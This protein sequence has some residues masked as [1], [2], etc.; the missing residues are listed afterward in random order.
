MPIFSPISASY[1]Q[2]YHNIGILMCI[3]IYIP[4]EQLYIYIYSSVLRHTDAL[5]SSR[6]GFLVASAEGQRS[7]ID[8]GV[9]WPQGFPCVVGLGALVEPGLFPADHPG[10]RRPRKYKVSAF[11]VFHGECLIFRWLFDG[12]SH[13][14][15]KA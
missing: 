12:I 2:H 7:G 9:E 13:V 1:L 11:M 14:Q 6:P 8:A 3:H 4:I 15:T 10:P 5:R